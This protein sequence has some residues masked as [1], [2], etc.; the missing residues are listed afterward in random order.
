MERINWYFVWLKRL[1]PFSI[2]HIVEEWVCWNG[3]EKTLLLCLLHVMHTLPYRSTCSVSL[4]TSGLVTAQDLLQFRAYWG[5]SCSTGLSQRMKKSTQT[6]WRA[7][8]KGR[9]TKKL[10]NQWFQWRKTK[11][12]IY[13]FMWMSQNLGVW[14]FCVLQMDLILFGGSSRHKCVCQRAS[15]VALWGLCKDAMRWK[16]H[17][18]SLTS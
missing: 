5:L 6:N 12:Y 15:H 3:N 9:A 7:L 8:W 13:I 17:L 11:W 2:S 18:G 16:I 1:I 10:R 14:L 4:Q